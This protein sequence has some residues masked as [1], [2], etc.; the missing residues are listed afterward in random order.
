MLLYNTILI[1]KFLLEEIVSLIYSLPLCEVFDY[2]LLKIKIVDD[3]YCRIE[4]NTTTIH[5]CIKEQRFFT[6]ILSHFKDKRL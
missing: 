5:L 4:G 2:I 6:F 3:I 1:F